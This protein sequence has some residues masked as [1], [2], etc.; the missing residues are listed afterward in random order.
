MTLVRMLRGYVG[1]SFS[2][3]PVMVAF[4]SDDLVE[5][6]SIG[7][8]GRRLSMNYG[9]IDA[10]VKRER[11]KHYKAS[12]GHL[13]IDESQDYIHIDWLKDYLAGHGKEL[14]QNQSIEEFTENL[15]NAWEVEYVKNLEEAIG[16]A[17]S[18]KHE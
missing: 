15:M 3:V 16:D 9:P 17:E 11:S 7:S 10:M 12:V 8:G 13:F 1:D 14:I 2:R 6:I 4:T 5:T 18:D